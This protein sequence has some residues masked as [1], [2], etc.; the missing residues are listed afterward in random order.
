MVF[1]VSFLDSE[2]GQSRR[3]EHDSLTRWEGQFT[4]LVTG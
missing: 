1:R 4:Y 2:D 3:R